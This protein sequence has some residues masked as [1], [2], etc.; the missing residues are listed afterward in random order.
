MKSHRTFRFKVKSSKL[1]LPRTYIIR[2]RSVSF[3][4]LLVSKRANSPRNLHNP[5]SMP[6]TRLTIALNSNQST[7]TPLLVPPDASLNPTASKSCCSLVFNAAKTKLRLKKPTRLFVQG[8]GEELLDEDG[9]KRALK[10]DAVLLVSAGEDYVGLRKDV[11][12]ED[13]IKGTYGRHGS[14]KTKP[15]L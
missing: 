13:E 12:R 2:S 8:T 1:P 10:N 7:K 6:P 5:T 14:S 9:W 4:F 11:I 3:L 15:S